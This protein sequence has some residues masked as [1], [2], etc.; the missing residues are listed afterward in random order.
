MYKIALLLFLIL[1]ST[2]FSI[3]TCSLSSLQDILLPSSNYG[4]ILF[5]LIGLSI[6]ILILAYFLGKVYRIPQIALLFSSEVASF[7]SIVVFISVLLSLSGTLCF[8]SPTE[9]FKEDALDR[10]EKMEKNLQSML[11]KTYS[12]SI[13]YLRKASLYD[14]TLFLLEGRFIQYQ[15]HPEASAYAMGFMTLSGMFMRLILSSISVQKAILI[16]SG[17]DIM[18]L[19]LVIGL[20]IRVLP[21][22]KDVGSLLLTIFVAFYLIYPFLMSVFLSSMDDIL[23]YYNHALCSSLPE[24]FSQMPTLECGKP[25]SPFASSTYIIFGSYVPTLVIGI[26]LEFIG[27]FRKV[28]D[29]EV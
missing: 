28:F 22:F 10:M 14:V 12:M 27:K 16:L 24:D 5:F 26:T 4:K 6:P 19:L 23:Q 7:F 20:I 13:E 18:V 2:S 3:S 17:S 29:I 15:K 11:L 1:L 9:D 8:L 21:F 25:Y